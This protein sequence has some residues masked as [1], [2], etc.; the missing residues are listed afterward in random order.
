MSVSKAGEV[1]SFLR[2]GGRLGAI[3]SAGVRY[4]GDRL[5]TEF[6]ELVAEHGG[7]ITDNP[8]G[9]FLESGTGVRTVTVFMRRSR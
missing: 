3:M 2:V 8:E 1:L 9:A 7:R 6:R 4:R 5:A